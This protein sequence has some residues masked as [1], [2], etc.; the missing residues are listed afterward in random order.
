MFNFKSGLPVARV[1]GGASDKT[2]IYLQKDPKGDVTDDEKM[3][4]ILDDGV[5]QPLPNIQAHETLFIAGPTE[6]GKTTYGAKYAKEYKKQFP[7]KKIVVF[8]SIDA[9]KPL[10]DLNPIRIDVTDPEIV[11][12]PIE[13]S[14]FQDDG[15][16][17]L[18][19]FDDYDSIKDKQIRGAVND[20]LE[21]SIKRGRIK[22]ADKL[23]QDERRLGDL[24]I[25]VM[26]HQLLNYKA[27]R[28]LL[29]EATSVTLFPA[30]GS[31]GQIEQFLKRYMSLNKKMSQRI[32]TL[33]SRWITIYKRF[34]N[35]VM[36][37]K[38]VFLL[39]KKFDEDQPKTR[40]KKVTSDL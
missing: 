6:S 21:E 4:R 23:T 7:E 9:D 39:S 26:G 15:V 20:L 10:D 33:P 5:L 13:V 2:I 34:P 22:S 36:W 1:V 31:T 24:D 18:L 37:E 35:F 38:G 16:G 32:L 3:I 8:S 17:S 19:V 28:E 40:A 12:N 14:E 30:A 29:N 27:T 11:E 25:V